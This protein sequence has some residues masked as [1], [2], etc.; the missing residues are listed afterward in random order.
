MAYKDKIVTLKY[1]KIQLEELSRADTENINSDDGNP[2]DQINRKTEII[3]DLAPFIKI[4]DYEFKANEIQKISI[5]EHNLIPTI[6]A[7]I[8][9]KTGLINGP[10]FP[11]NSP[12]LKLYI[13][14]K[15][16]KYK[17]IRND[18]LITKIIPGVKLSEGTDKSDGVGTV[19]TIMGY[20]NVP[21]LF[22]GDSRSYK[23]STSLDVLSELSEELDL[24]FATNDDKT[25]D[26]MTWINPYLERDVF[27]KE[28]TKHAYKDDNSFY[29]SFI[30]KYYNLNFINVNEMLSGSSDIREIYS[31]Y[32]S[33]HQYLRGDESNKSENK[34]ISS[35]LILSNMSLM[36]GS[37]LY[38]RD[39]KQES[40]HGSI[41]S[42]VGEDGILLYYNP[43]IDTEDPTNNFVTINLKNDS[44]NQV[45][46]DRASDFNKPSAYWVG[47][48]YNNSHGDYFYSE[49]NNLYKNMN[50]KKITLRVETDGVNLNVIRGM[51]IPI[52]IVKHGRA[53]ENVFGPEL[54]EEEI[55]NVDP[56]ILKFE[57]E[58]QFKIDRYLSG[59]YHIIGT[60]YNF[61]INS[62]EG[63]TLYS[64]E[65]ILTKVGL[66]RSPEKIDV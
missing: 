46:V 49:L 23:N 56:R 42:E 1:P 66:D 30:D 50:I 41:L 10:F 18:Y 5:S 12:I 62:S 52:L 63:R 31:S 64:T 54:E 6:L 29:T 11:K 39:Y 36:R 59:F 21:K 27:I 4:G 53:A 25:N 43:Y 51:R 26:T 14:S 37:D 34:E 32:I 44:Y 13:K 33:Q 7:T 9:D 2:K 20:L 55:K 61:D 60:Q 24:G 28:I 38:I 3:G 19:Y 47:F 17:P 65:L 58:N 48:D 8:I 57:R 16:D 15:S 45:K 22:K 35:K 40:M